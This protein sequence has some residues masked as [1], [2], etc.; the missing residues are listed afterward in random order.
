M[1]T[2]QQQI[3]RA[4]S[5]AC[6]DGIGSKAFF[7]LSKIWDREKNQPVDGQVRFGS[8]KLSRVNAMTRRINVRLYS[9]LPADIA[10]Q[11]FYEPV[12]NLQALIGELLTKENNRLAVVHDAGHSVL[13][14]N[15]V[16]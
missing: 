10:R 13:Q 3:L 11:V 15:K 14:L 1:E 8:H 4:Y 12:G 6:E 16:T 2:E 5:E 9:E 7:E